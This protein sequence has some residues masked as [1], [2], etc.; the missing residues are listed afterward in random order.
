MIY[1]ESD[2][3]S[4]EI[5]IKQIRFFQKQYYKAQRHTRVS[6]YPVNY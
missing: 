4:D 5:K 3:S 1:R 2:S 6:G